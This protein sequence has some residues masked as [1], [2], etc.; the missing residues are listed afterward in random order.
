MSIIYQQENEIQDVKDGQIRGCQLR[1]LRVNP[2][3]D[4][5]YI[6]LLRLPSNF[7][8]PA[9]MRHKRS[10]RD[11]NVHVETVRRTMTIPTKTYHPDILR[12]LVRSLQN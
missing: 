10:R 1:V 4:R 9:F 8:Y 2:G 3:G 12:Y 11:R 6:G 5:V 7:E